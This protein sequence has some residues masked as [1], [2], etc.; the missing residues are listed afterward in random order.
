MIPIL[1]FTG[2]DEDDEDD[3]SWYDDDESLSAP[4]LTFSED[5]EDDESESDSRDN[6]DNEDEERDSV[7][8]NAVSDENV[9]ES[10]PSEDRGSGAVRRSRSINILGSES[11]TSG[12]DSDADGA[13]PCGR[14]GRRTLRALGLRNDDPMP[15]V[16]PRV[17]RGVDDLDPPVDDWFFFDEEDEHASTNRYVRENVVDQAQFENS[18]DSDTVTDDDDEEDQRNAE[19]APNSAS[20]GGPNSAPLGSEGKDKSESTR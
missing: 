7:S 1:Y 8:P 20:G 5:E 2:G 15:T 3:P 6:S 13:A 10:T 4:S 12:S 19:V 16:R 14:F 9:R 11:T 17:R 18:T